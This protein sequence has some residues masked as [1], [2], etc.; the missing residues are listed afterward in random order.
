MSETD[1]QGPHRGNDLAGVVARALAEDLG[2]GD[3]TTEATVPEGA[4][5]MARSDRRLVSSVPYRRILCCAA[6]S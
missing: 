5:G 6:R 2:P 1:A 4:R 3:V